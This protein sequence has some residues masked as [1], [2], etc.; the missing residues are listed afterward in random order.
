MN[1]TLLVIIDPQNDFI[2]QTGFYAKKHSGI[3]QILNA[4]QKINKILHLYNK[5]KIVIVISDYEKDQFEKGL[6]ICIPGTVGHK[7]DIQID[8]TFTL[9]SKK[10]HSCFSSKAFNTYLETNFVDRI[11]LCGFL[12]EYCV[13]QTAIDGLKIGYQISL[14]KECIGTGDNVQSRKEQMLIELADK[15]AEILTDYFF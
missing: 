2:N 4:R 12:A 5:E 13:K 8:N 3:D 9:I 6:S 10:N 1:N 11:I 14:L 15:G 7:I